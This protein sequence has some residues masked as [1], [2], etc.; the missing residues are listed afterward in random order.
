[1][2][3]NA[4]NDTPSPTSTRLLLAL[5]FTGTL[6]GALDLAIIG[7]ALPDIQKEFGMQQRELAGLINSYT[8]LQMMGALLLAK[9]SDRVGP[10]LIYIVSI[11]LFAMG[12]L[13]LVMAEN[14]NTLYFGR[15]MQG[16]G[17]G[18][19]FPAAASVIGARL[20]PAK[21]GP[22]LGILGMV[23]GMAFLLGPIL[24]GIFL[25]F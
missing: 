18:G 12:S 13:L 20:P 17:A 1:M 9:M 10:R 7:P 14:S 16:F 22:A 24:G 15:A 8:L 4:M 2:K 6:M 23:W 19:V 5:L 21:R 11:V 3:N 25:R